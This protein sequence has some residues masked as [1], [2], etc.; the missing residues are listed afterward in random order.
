MSLET[1]SSF[2]K[3]T[4]YLKAISPQYAT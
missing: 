3:G 4:P 1:H 2:F